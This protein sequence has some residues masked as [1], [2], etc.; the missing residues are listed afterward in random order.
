[1]CPWYPWSTVVVFGDIH[2]GIDQN[3]EGARWLHGVFDRW[4][5]LV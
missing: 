4:M 3:Q 5:A 2:V 1:M